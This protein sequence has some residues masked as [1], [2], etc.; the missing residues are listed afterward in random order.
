M[1]NESDIIIEED[2]LKIVLGDIVIENANA[3]TINHLLIAEKGTF[4]QFPTVGGGLYSLNNESYT[5][6]RPLLAKIQQ[7]LINDGM[8]NIIITSDTD[9]NIQITADR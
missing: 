4:K 3:Q 9:N 5:D 8:S 1:P 6:M 7:T 2:D